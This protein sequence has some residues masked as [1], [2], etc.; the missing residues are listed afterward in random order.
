MRMV[1]ERY[2]RHPCLEA[3]KKSL[4]QDFSGACEVAIL[5]RKIGSLFQIASR[6]DLRILDW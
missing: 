1:E 5:D 6:S 4:D 3:T 2:G